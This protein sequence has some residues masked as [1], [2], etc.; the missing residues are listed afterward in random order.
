VT[1]A[2]PVIKSQYFYETRTFIPPDAINVTPTNLSRHGW[3][4][5]TCRETFI[6][7]WAYSLL[8]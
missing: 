3:Y 2:L 8:S 7:F 6:V 5:S 1:V 4:F